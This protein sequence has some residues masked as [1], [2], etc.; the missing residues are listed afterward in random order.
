MKSMPEKL[1]IYVNEETS[2]WQ[3]RNYLPKKWRW[4]SLSSF[5]TSVGR[6]ST[7]WR[8]GSDRKSG[9]T[10][11]EEKLILRNE[12]R[13]GSYTRETTRGDGKRVVY[14]SCYQVLSFEDNRLEDKFERRPN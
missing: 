13:K 8:H 14:G 3:K 10:E 12:R 11:E 9:C 2:S 4:N 7:I 1:K 6:I 5:K